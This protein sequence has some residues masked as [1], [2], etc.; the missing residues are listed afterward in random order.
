MGCY[1]RIGLIALVFINII[2]LSALNDEVYAELQCYDCHGIRAAADNRPVDASFRNPSNGGFQGNHRNHLESGATPNSCQKCHPGSSSY[3]PGHRDGKIKL[4]GSINSSHP[5]TAYNN[6]TTAFLQRS[7]PVLGRCANVN[8]HFESTTPVWGGA[9]LASPNDCNSCHGAPPSGGT[10]GSAGSHARHDGYYS[11]V[12]NCIKCHSDHTSD[13]KPFAHATSVGKRNLVVAPKDPLNAPT[14]TYDGAVNDYLPSQINSFGSCSALYCHSNAAPF[15]KANATATPLWGGGAQSCSS[16]HDGGGDGSGLSGRHARHTGGT[17]NFTCERCHNATVAGNS[18]IKSTA[19][20]VNKSKDVT[21]KE[22]GSYNSG[23]RACDSTYCHSNAAG[24]APR[25]SVKWSDSGVTMT[26]Y[27]CH[28]GRTADSTPENCAAVAGTWSSA[29][30]YCTPDL[31]MS[32]NGHHRLTGPQWIRKYPCYYCHNNTI[33]ASG[34]IKSTGLHVNGTMDVSMAPQWNIVGRPAASYNQGT[35]ICD[36]VYCHSDGST[37]PEQVRPFAWTAPKTECNTCHGHPAGSC[38]SAN[39]HDGRIDG[40]TGKNWAVKTGWPAGSEWMGAMPMFPNQGAGTARANSHPRHMM[41]NFTCDNCHAATVISGSCTNCHAGGIPPGGM[42]EVAHINATYHVN[43]TKDVVF[44]DGGSYNS[45]LKT[46]SNTKCHTSGTDPVWGGSVNAAIT[47]LGCHGTTGADRDT[48]RAFSGYSQA[49]I[50]LTQFYTTGHGRYSSSG[51]YPVSGNPAANFPGNP[52]WYCH[53]NT[54]LHKDATN[55]FRLRKHLQYEKRFD[56]ECVY[57]HMEGAVSECLGCHNTAESLA[58]QLTSPTVI[59]K[60]SGATQMSGCGKSSGC[61]NNNATIHKTNNNKWWSNSEKSDVKN[62]YVMMGVCLQCHDDDSSNQCTSCHTAPAENP[63]KYSLGFDPGMEGSRFVKPKKARAS[64][65]HFGYKHYQ[66]YQTDGIWRGGKFC[67]DCH[68][69]HGDSNI[70]MIHDKVATTTDGT[71]GIPLTRADVSFTRKQSGLDYARTSAPYNGICNVCHVPGNKHYTSV[72]GDGHN[73]SRVCTTCHEHRFA[74]SH[75]NKMDCN[76]SGCHDNKKPVPRHLAFG[77]PRDCTKCHNGTIGMRMDVMGQFRSNSHHIQ[78]VNGEIKNT[79]CYQCHWEANSNGLINLLY[80]EGFNYLNY[81]SSKNNKVDLV[82]YGAGVRPTVY[83]NNSS[84]VQFWAKNIGTASERAEVGKI[85]NQCLGCHSDKNKTTE[86]FGDCKTPIQYSWDRSSVAARY[87]QAGTTTWGKYVGTTNAAQ[88]NITKAFSAHGNATANGGGWSTQTGTDGAIPNTRN[89]AN[90]VQCFDCHNSHGSKAAGTTSSYVTFNGTKNGANLK[91]TQAGK[92]GYAMTYKASANGDTNST[93]PYSTGAG[94]CFD[95][96]LTRNSGLTPWGYF[97]TFGA[98]SSVRGYTD[99]DRFSGTGMN[100]PRQR[101]PYK[102]SN[103]NPQKG[104]HFKASSTIGTAPMGTIDGLCTPC[105]DP[106]GVSPSLGNDQA[107][108]VPLLKGTWMTSPYKEDMAI[109]GNST[110]DRGYTYAYGNIK[111]PAVA[112]STANIH[113]DQNTFSGTTRVSED[114]TRFAGLCMRCHAKSS[115]T[116]EPD[117]TKAWKSR[118]RIHQSVKGWGVNDKHAYTC[119]KCHQPHFSKLPRLMV[120]NC[121]DPKHRG[122]V[123]SGGTAASDNGYQGRGGFPI[124]GS[125]YGGQYRA[126][127]HPDGAWPNNL[128]NTKTPW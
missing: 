90:S 78:R 125:A 62:Q 117:K 29:R 86:P 61:H 69:P 49:K 84:V 94:Q 65:A 113:I 126:N 80:H 32:S 82:I 95:C 68:D 67:W 20:H 45:I 103:S 119:S 127:C 76:T 6:S 128:W 18:S 74:D 19:L 26:C 64:S 17:Y 115:L 88:K 77:L 122:R 52:C 10:T 108:A 47:C 11:G 99:S 3:L 92:G 37:D 97:S 27:S 63:L 56:K 33:D 8:C 107:Y 40:V 104:G 44:K 110:G 58:P 41:T 9:A 101:T 16:C 71:Y 7:R 35:K 124:G 31:T 53:D 120:T 106:H 36:N 2:L 60:H 70:F 22:G 114:D 50:N 83:K 51:R 55:P 14:G 105:H 38:S 28:K 1:K 111:P 30:G 46:C 73:A 87:S 42:G 121:L 75:A 24:G 109:S 123:T 89:G 81:S 48:Y 23:T 93:N 43:K 13:P 118:D 12:N 79:D 59:A 5:V 116:A 15:D 57:C 112:D 72:N 91:E 34:A 39:C 102:N 66:A 21:F 25:V 96:H 100:G 98:I 85:T 54:V 4:S